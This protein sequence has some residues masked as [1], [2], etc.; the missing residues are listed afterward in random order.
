VD[1]D[2]F[3]PKT[4]AFII[5]VMS[6]MQADN[7]QQAF[8]L[9]AVPDSPIKDKDAREHVQQDVLEARNAQLMDQIQ[10]SLKDY[11]RVIVPWGAMHL[12]E[13]ETWL[14]SQKFKQSGEIERKAL[15]F[16]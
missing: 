6:L 12:P 4:I 5:A 3:H 16:W 8:Q 7:W 1:V 10:S 13:I 15:S 11:R 14:R 2:T 9:M